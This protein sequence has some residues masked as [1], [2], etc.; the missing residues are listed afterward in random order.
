MSKLIDHGVNARWA[1]RE[2]AV[3]L[4]KGQLGL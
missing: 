4:V 2:E 1:D 3:A